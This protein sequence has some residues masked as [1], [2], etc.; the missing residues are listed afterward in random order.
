[1]KHKIYFPQFGKRKV[2]KKNKSILEHIK[3]LGIPITSECSGLGI[4]KKCKITVIKGME[5]LNKRTEHESGLE[6]RERLACQTIVEDDS[7][8]I[9]INI[10]H[11][12]AIK[13]ILTGGKS[14]VINVDPL[15]IKAN[16][17]VLFN[18]IELDNYKG[19]IYGIAIDIGTTTV[20]LHLC[21][22]ESGEIIF[23]S[24]FENPQ[25]IINGNNVISRIEFDRKFPN[26][27]HKILIDYINK[28]IKE[29]PCNP[30]EI[31]EAVVVGNSTMRD[32]FF[33]IDVQTLGVKP[34][35]SITEL[36]GNSTFLNKKAY[37][38]S[39]NL[40]KKANVYGVPLISS[41]LG[42]DTVAMCLFTGLFDNHKEVVISIDIGTNGEVV[43][44]YDNEIIA[45]S[46]AAGPAFEQIPAIE[47]A[48]QKIFFDKGNIILRTIGNKKA[49]GICGSG[50]I[51]LLAVLLKNKEMDENGYLTKGKKFNIT[52]KIYLTQDQIKS[53]NG[54]IWSKAAISLGIKALL[55]KANLKTDDIDKVYLS[56]SFGSY[57]N[58][59]NSIKIGLVPA[60]QIEKIVQVGNAAAEGAIEILLFKERRKLAE[61][62]AMKVKHMSL[63]S[64]PNYFEKL[65]LEEQN[66]TELKVY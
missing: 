2:I 51:D 11:H 8:D 23:T 46:C 6:S 62:S 45:T 57:I 48:I 27:L 36:E 34:F 29:M 20:V 9:Y 30:S 64:I 31:Y 13:Q 43:L 17:K 18:N 63:E 16:N 33:G 21:D 4:C 42:S 3:E 14:K 25:R 19:H 5:A 1:M 55:E 28:K 12:G 60:I 35:K 38:L 66:F 39:L 52:D 54:L 10:L 53:Q 44:K 65:I 49:I 50:I 61:I 41:H 22:L 15:T 59:E 40:N 37:E 26:D 7:I 56:G 58:I 32:I 47:G 24:T